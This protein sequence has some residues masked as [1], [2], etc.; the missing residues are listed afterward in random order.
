MF[1][2][3]VSINN[4]NCN[5]SCC[6]CRPIFVEK[7]NAARSGPCCH[8]VTDVPSAKMGKHPLLYGNTVFVHFTVVSVFE[9]FIVYCAIIYQHLF[10]P[11]CFVDLFISRWSG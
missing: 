1:L 7:F 11:G 9:T 4:L 10:F 2:L 5:V 3:E 6:F 8:R